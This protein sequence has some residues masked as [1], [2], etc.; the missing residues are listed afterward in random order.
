MLNKTN[1][2]KWQTINQLMLTVNAKSLICILKDGSSEVE[3]SSG[4][5]IQ[6]HHLQK[7][8]YENQQHGVRAWM[9]EEQKSKGQ[10]YIGPH[11]DEDFFKSPP[12]ISFAK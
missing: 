11:K 4:K 8:T 1:H 3:M 12:I 6:S 9:S 10:S 2:H 5:A 7:I